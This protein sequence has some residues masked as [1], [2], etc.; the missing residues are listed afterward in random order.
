MTIFEDIANFGWLVN[1]LYQ[2]DAGLW[3]CNLRKPDATGDWFTN[4]AE[5]A[6]LEDVLYEALFLTE[7]AEFTHTP[8]SRITIDRSEAPS[9]LAKLGLTRKPTPFTDRRL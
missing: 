1:N 3:R 6:T 7:A 5:A 4:W 2:V 8:E 9:L